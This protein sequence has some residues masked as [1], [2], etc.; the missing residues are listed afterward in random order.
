MAGS[1]FGRRRHMECVR[2]LLEGGA[3]PT[4]AGKDGRDAIGW[5]S[6]ANQH[7]VLELFEARGCDVGRGTA[8]PTDAS[9]ACQNNAELLAERRGSALWGRRDEH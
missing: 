2:L 1:S 9:D 3:E 5:A 6:H 4:L 8:A 7:A